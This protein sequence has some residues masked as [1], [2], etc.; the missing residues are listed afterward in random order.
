MIVVSVNDAAALRQ[1]ER[2]AAEAE[3]LAASL[4]YLYMATDTEPLDEGGDEDGGRE[5]AQ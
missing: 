3:D 5:D 4:D 1:L 2:Q